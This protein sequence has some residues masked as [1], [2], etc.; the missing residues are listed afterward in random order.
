MGG[1]AVYKRPFSSFHQLKT[2]KCSRK[3]KLSTTNN[4]ITVLCSKR[5]F[6]TFDWLNNWVIF[7]KSPH[8]RT[9]YYFKHVCLNF[10]TSKAC[11]LF[12]ICVTQ[13]TH[14]GFTPVKLDNVLVL[15][16]N[17]VP[18]SYD[19]QFSGTYIQ[20]YRATTHCNSV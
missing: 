17:D 16:K 15:F 12:M 11:R 2:L 10:R 20:I 13:S 9:K 1:G 8:G 5:E 3:E 6:V 18:A 19:F 14:I 7:S 4:L